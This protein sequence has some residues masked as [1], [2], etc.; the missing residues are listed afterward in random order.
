MHPGLFLK[1]KFVMM[2]VFLLLFYVCSALLM[3]QGMNAT[4]A[5]YIN[6]IF[7]IL[8]FVVKFGRI[9]HMCRNSLAIYIL[10]LSIFTAVIMLVTDRFYKMSYLFDCMMCTAMF[11]L[12]FQST[13]NSKNTHNLVLFIFILFILNSLFSYYERFNLI[14]LFANQWQETWENDYHNDGLDFIFRSTALLGHPLNNAL[15]AAVMMQAILIMPLKKYIKFLLWGMGLL[16]LLCFNARGATICSILFLAIYLVKEAIIQHN[17]KTL[18]IIVFLSCIGIY[19]FMLI[20]SSSLMGRL[21]TSG[22][23]DESANERIRVW[24]PINRMEAI[25]LL[26]GFT[27]EG[28]RLAFKAV[29]LYTMENW[30]AGFIYH[31]GIPLTISFL[32]LY[33]ILFFKV[34][35]KMRRFDKIFLFGGFMVLSSLNNSLSMGSW[36][37]IWTFCVFYITVNLCTDYKFFCSKSKY[38]NI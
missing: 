16:S 21:I 34:L 35:K 2:V 25:D 12:I 14:N 1:N 38:L 19:F 11:I 23:M 27:E 24:L 3:P 31:M 22:L 37:W 17:F 18:F 28:S 30:L 5:V 8:L 10:I 13:L 29:K 26:F 33:F 15:S 9:I 4:L 32:Y 7:T 6:L 20:S 36:P